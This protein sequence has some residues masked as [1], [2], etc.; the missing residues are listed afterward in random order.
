MPSKL[1]GV[2]LPNAPLD[3]KPASPTITELP[4][5]AMN[6]IKLPQVAKRTASS[7]KKPTSSSKDR[8]G[9][10]DTK[11]KNAAHRGSIVSLQQ[12][13]V[14]LGMVMESPPALLIG[15]STQSTGALISGR[16]Q[17]IPLVAEATVESIILY[18]E[19]VTTTKR[20]VQD[21]C[22]ECQSQSVDMYEWTFLTKPTIFWKQDGVQEMPFSHMI[23][24][25][26]P[27]T[28][29]GHIGSIDYSL[30]IRARTGDGQEVELRRELILRRALVPGPERHSVRIFPPTNLNLQVT[31]PNVIHPLGEFPVECRMT[32]IVSKK[33]ES[34]TQWRL[35]KLTWRIE[36]VESMISPACQKHAH[37]VGGE[38]KGIQHEQTRDL[39]WEE[40][41]YGWKT[42][43]EDATIEGEFLASIDSSTKP[44][45]GVEAQNG[46]E[47]KHNL[48]LEMVIA[49][50]WA[51]SKKPN[52]P[53]P[54]GAARVLRTQ[55][56]LN[57]TERA[58]MG[59]AWDDE[60]PPSYEDVPASP[61][62]YKNQ[63]TT[64]ELYEGDDLHGDIEQWTLE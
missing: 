62:H 23:P 43:F 63:H 56:P 8:S 59:L 47:I 40:L 34:Q 10:K 26:L 17:V 44:Q 1:F 54:T 31:L 16:L 7:D 38:G 35:R 24:G 14:K 60:M 55:F 41:R 6:H 20:P 18:L 46:L 30:H 9:S 22:R 49:E 42:N 4:Q 3:R 33:D 19:C 27:A 36:E 57:V 32:G 15:T 61:P 39:G 51:K 48:I 53:T 13:V 21:R 12:K 45:C 64:V 58:G 5:A 11:D 50:E 52:S 25:H 37:K 29:H 2:R 28:T